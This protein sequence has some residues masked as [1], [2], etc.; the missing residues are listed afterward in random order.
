MNKKNKMK[1]IVAMTVAMAFVTPVAAFVNVGTSGIT[2]NSE[3]TNMATVVES[4]NNDDI[5]TIIDAED[6]IIDMENPSTETDT[7]SMVLPTRNTVYVDDD[8]TEGPWDGS[9][10]NPYQYIHDGFEKE[11]PGTSGCAAVLRLTNYILR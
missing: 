7:T 8:N 3:N 5:R 10:E 1:V 9:P 4:T 11:L 2:P 6:L